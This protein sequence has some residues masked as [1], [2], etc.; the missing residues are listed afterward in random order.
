LDEG[1]Q[2]TCVNRATARQNFMWEFVSKET[3][4]L[5]TVKCIL[6]TPDSIKI[7]IFVPTS[8]FCH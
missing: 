8:N 5:K 7:H 6:D 1:K 2:L 3:T 4:Q